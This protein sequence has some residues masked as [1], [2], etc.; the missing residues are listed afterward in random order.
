M[1]EDT[2]FLTKAAKKTQETN[3]AVKCIEEILML[4]FGDLR[5]ATRVA[6]EIR[7]SNDAIKYLVKRT[8]F[9]VAQAIFAV[10]RVKNEPDDVTAKMYLNKIAVDLCKLLQKYSDHG[11][12][13]N[14][15]T[16]GSLIVLAVTYITNHLK[17]HTLNAVHDCKMKHLRK[18]QECNTNFVY[19]YTKYM[20]TLNSTWYSVLT[21]I[22]ELLYCTSVKAEAAT[23]PQVIAT[24]QEFY[25]VTDIDASGN[26]V[27]FSNTKPL[28]TVEQAVCYA[29][30]KNIH[31]LTAIIS[32]VNTG[33]KG[34]FKVVPIPGT[35][36]ITVNI[37]ND[38]K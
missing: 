27:F 2:F 8:P 37:V 24:P 23:K 19:D 15:V 14:I 12:T 20:E 9:T 38:R 10:C 25:I 13:I 21:D 11:S 18:V 26:P 1:P 34:I 29:A 28:P 31:A 6:A 35:L 16:V 30:D 4:R 33:E 22:E 36:S 17:G 7:T 32:Q 3:K 5:E